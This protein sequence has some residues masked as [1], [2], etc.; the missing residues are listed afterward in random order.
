MSPDGVLLWEMIDPIPGHTN[1]SVSYTVL[2]DVIVI[3]NDSECGGN[4]YFTFNV[5]CCS[6]TI[7]TLKD[8]CPPRAPSFSGVWSKPD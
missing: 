4:G 5:T 1:S 8:Y 6:L 3:Y 2:E 7:T